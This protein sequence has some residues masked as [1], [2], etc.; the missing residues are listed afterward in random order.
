MPGEL[1]ALLSHHPQPHPQT[2]PCIHAKLVEV[3]A[4]LQIIATASTT[5]VLG[6]G[7]KGEFARALH[8]EHLRP[9]LIEGLFAVGELVV[10]AGE[11]EALRSGRGDEHTHKA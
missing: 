11:S 9:L 3:C 7:T 1:D 10:P 8:S 5:H 2:A 6:D 4:D